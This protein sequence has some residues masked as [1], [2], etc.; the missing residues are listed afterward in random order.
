MKNKEDDINKKRIVTV[1]LTGSRG[2]KEK[3][4]NTPISPD[5][6]IEDAYQSYLCGAS[7]AHIHVKDDQ[8]INAEINNEKFEYIKK[9]IREK[10]DMILNFSTSGET[11]E[12]NG[13]SLIGT[14]D[15]I[16]E[17]R[18]NILD[19]K[20]E[21]A[22]YDLGTM[23]FNEQIFM[24][25]IG[26]LRKLGK[27]MQDLSILPELEVYSLGDIEQAKLLIEEGYLPENVYFQICLGIR[28]GA[29]ATVKNLL[30]MQE[31]LPENCNWGAF[32]IG[33]DNLKIM[34][35]TI[36]LGG[37]TRVGLEDNLY[38]KKGQKTTNV[39][40]VKRARRI[41]EEF[42]SEVANPEETRKILNIEE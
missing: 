37:N 39:E 1:A 38:Y 15:L 29:P 17:K 31:A 14:Q 3:N 13:L 28:G 32:G 11:N 7:I 10:C 41:I 42:G 16:Q 2:S 5:E 6:I 25:P 33:K 34:Y 4:I 30:V 20:P 9:A 27:K 22:S 19:T 18:L 40:L 26:F 24:N 35:A 12:V 23:N 36:A 8:G 21:I